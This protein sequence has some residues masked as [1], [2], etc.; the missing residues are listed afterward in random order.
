M[1]IYEVKYQINTR[2]TIIKYH[3]NTLYIVVSN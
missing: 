3:I 2:F 1:Y